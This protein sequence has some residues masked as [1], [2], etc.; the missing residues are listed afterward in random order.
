MTAAVKEHRS[1]FERDARIMDELNRSLSRHKFQTNCALCGVQDFRV[2]MEI[3][4]DQWTISSPPSG[5]VRSLAHPLRTV[6]SSTRTPEKNGYDGYAGDGR[7][8]R[9]A[10]CLRSREGLHSRHLRSPQDVRRSP[11]RGRAR[12]R[13]RAVRGT[14]G[15]PSARPGASRRDGHLTSAF[16]SWRGFRRDRPPPSSAMTLRRRSR[17]DIRSEKR[18]DARSGR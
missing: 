6:H 11:P 9:R 3:Y 16:Q 18:T 1:S 2:A 5:R 12:A 7:D 13:V 4:V 8:G 17:C 14:R 15:R 10:P